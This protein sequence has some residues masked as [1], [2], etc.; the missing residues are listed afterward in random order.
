MIDHHKRCISL[1][2]D[3]SHRH[4][5]HQVFSDFCELSALAISNAVDLKQHEA[6]EARYMQII[7]RYDADEIRRFPEMLACCTLALEHHR[8]DFLGKLFMDLDLGSHWAGQF[9]T[10]YDLTKMMAKMTLGDMT[11][12]RIAELGGFITAC[13]P[14][15]GAGAMVIGMADA[16]ADLKINYQQCLHVTAVDLDATAT[17]MAFIQASL[18]HIPAIIVHGNSLSL[19]QFG[20]WLTPAHVFGGWD[21]RLRRRSAT[22]RP[23]DAECAQIIMPAP[24]ASPVDRIAEVRSSIVTAREQMALF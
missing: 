21:F 4:R 15:C 5:L 18:L 3:N 24:D 19:E 22:H 10:P 2:R 23:S 7:K 12:E 14:A 11:A 9:F 8:H 6:R 20:Y 13:E 1:L 16:L 17:H